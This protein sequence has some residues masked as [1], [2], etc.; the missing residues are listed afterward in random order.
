MESFSRRS[1]TVHIW[2]ESDARKRI[3]SAR[4]FDVTPDTFVSCR[5]R[6]IGSARSPQAKKKRG[7]YG[8]ACYATS[9]VLQ[10]IFGSMID[11]NALRARFSL[12]FTVPR[13]QSVMSAISSYDLPSS[14]RNTN[15]CR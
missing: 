11:A 6:S 10:S 4:R 3:D 5:T 9:Y 13:L 14:S 1:N 15:T 2:H 8:P 7:L 12:D